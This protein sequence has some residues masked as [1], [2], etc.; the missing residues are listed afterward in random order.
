MP[1]SNKTGR[2]QSRCLRLCL[3]L[4]WWIGVPC[5]VVYIALMASQATAAVFD[6]KL[7]DA[8]KILQESEQQNA[9][10]LRE[11]WLIVADAN[12]ED[13]SEILQAI[14]SADH[15]GANWLAM[16]VG[17][18]LE[19][20][21]PVDSEVEKGLVSFLADSANT[22]IARKTALAALQRVNPDV[23]S[24]VALGLIAD[25]VAELRRPAVDARI[26]KAAAMADDNESKETQLSAYREALIHARD[27]DQVK[28][29]AK[30]M[31]ELGSPVK[32]ADH[33]GFVQHWQISGPFD[34]AKGSGFDQ[35]Y[36][37]EK[38]S[39]RSGKMLAQLPQVDDA[40]V[41]GWKLFSADEDSGEVDLNQAVSPVEQ[42]IAYG[43]AQIDYQGEEDVELRF[44]VQNSFKCWLNGELIYSQPIG[45]TGNFFDQYRVPVKLK[46]GSNL[47]LIKS[48]Q[49]EPLQD[50]DWFKVWQF[51]VRLSDSTGAAVEFTQPTMMNTE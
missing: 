38:L 35:A 16:A 1:E 4:Q 21:G 34:N 45:H 46:R 12:G 40:S 9:E 15:L 8:L 10:Q 49:T 42:G 48:C 2:P 24:E 51:A 29:I 37:P 47:L 33:F 7:S 18:V 3:P 11:Q 39:V 44:Q 31:N 20:S 13:L 14:N 17:A 41:D 6:D 28:S 36:P 19:R 22:A 26:K 27:A 5:L 25:P 50:I 32:L 30:A 23:A 43:I